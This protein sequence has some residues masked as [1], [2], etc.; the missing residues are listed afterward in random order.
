MPKN[1]MDTLNTEKSNGTAPTA[2]VAVPDDI[3]D[4]L[5]VGY[6]ALLSDDHLDQLAP[7]SEQSLELPAFATV[8]PV[9]GA[10]P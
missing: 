8:V 7:S 4:R 5:L 10:A 9:G 6:P 2:Q 3:L 1:N